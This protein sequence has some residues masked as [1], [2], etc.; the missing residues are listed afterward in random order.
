MWGAG[1]DARYMFSSF[2]TFTLQKGFGWEV[3][4]GESLSN[5]CWSVGTTV[6]LV[7]KGGT[8]SLHFASR[9]PGCF[10]NISWMESGL[11]FA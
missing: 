8:C 1:D 9:L 3:C 5:A 10:S 4:V 6:T 11:L 7:E 2:P